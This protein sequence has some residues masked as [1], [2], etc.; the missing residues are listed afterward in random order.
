MIQKVLNQ[1]AVENKSEDRLQ[2]VKNQELFMFSCAV[3]VPIPV[4]LPLPFFLP[5]GFLWMVLK[6]LSCVALKP[7]N[8]CLA[9]IRLPSLVPHKH[10]MLLLKRKG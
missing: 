1:T 5:N 8:I 7:A 10:K 6:S 4:T 2:L 3:S 9:L